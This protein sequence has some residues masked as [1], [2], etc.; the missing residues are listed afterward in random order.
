MHNLGATDIKFKIE[1]QTLLFK[2]TNYLTWHTLNC[3]PFFV[4]RIVCFSHRL[5][6][7]APICGGSGTGENLT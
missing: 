3:E 2:T 7:T 1:L 6:S 5:I 4:K